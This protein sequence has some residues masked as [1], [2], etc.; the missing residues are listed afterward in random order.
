MWR[1]SKIDF[2]ITRPRASEYKAFYIRVEINH[3]IYIGTV[4]RHSAVSEKETL[5]HDS[6]F[7]SVILILNVHFL[8]ECPQAVFKELRLQRV[9]QPIGRRGGDLLFD[10]GQEGF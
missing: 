9:A 1:S 8:Y 5:I 4:T 2:I 7:R 6:V 3:F 10:K